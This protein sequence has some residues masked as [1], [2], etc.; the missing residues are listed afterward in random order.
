M[1]G[2]GREELREWK[3]GHS[4]VSTQT[5]LLAPTLGTQYPRGPRAV[6]G[7]TSRFLMLP[8]CGH[9]GELQ[10]CGSLG[11]GSEDDASRAKDLADLVSELLPL[12]YAA[13]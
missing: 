11:N 9:V 5:R 4:L 7:T 6:L 12:H 1:T 13:P 8:P 3:R 2:A 10:P